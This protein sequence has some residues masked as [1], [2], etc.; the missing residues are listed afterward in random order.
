[1]LIN[2]SPAGLRKVGAAYDLALALAVLIASEQVARPLAPTLVC[3]ELTLGGAVQPVRGAMAAV[4][5]ARRRGVGA[6]LV[7]SPNLAEAAAVGGDAVVGV[8]SLAEAARQVGRIGDLSTAPVAART[9]GSGAATVGAPPPG[10]PARGAPSPGGPSP[11]RQQLGSVSDIRGHAILKRALLIAAAGGH[12]L[13][14]FG[15][16]GTGKTMAARRLVGLLPALTYPQSVEA[17]QIQSLAGALEPATGLARWPPFREPHHSA[18]PEGLLGG[19]PALSPGEVSL[20]HEGVLLLDEVPEFPRNALQGLREPL[21]TGVVHVTRAGRSASFPARFQ[22][23]A[24]A[25]PCPCGALGRQ[26]AACACSDNDIKRYWKRLGGALLDRID[27]RVPLQAV[28]AAQLLAPLPS[29]AAAADDEEM[30]TLVARAI[31][32]QRAR[33]RD[34]PWGRNGRLPAHATQS[35]CVLDEPCRGEIE[36]SQHVAELSSRALHSVARV[37]RTIAD[38]AGSARIGTAHVAEAI[39]FRRYGDADLFWLRS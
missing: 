30:A 28:P 21:E 20:A 16:P 3:G 10:E 9:P 32:T 31:A 13:L 34:A 4:L 14:L 25:N 24:T 22:L 6:F 29:E 23:V 19:S 27:V 2:L 15:P 26:T 7:P 12:H 35:H 33:Y 37:A 17:T 38:L 8:A 11:W 5:A 39:Q 36:R 18:S 1:M